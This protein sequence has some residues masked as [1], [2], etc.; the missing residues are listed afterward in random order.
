LPHDGVKI[1]VHVNKHT[2]HT[3]HPAELLFTEGCPQMD[4]KSPHE[5]GGISR[6]P[7]RRGKVA[8]KAENN[9]EMEHGE[10]RVAERVVR[11]EAEK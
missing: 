3:K 9:N 8:R 2:K 10:R 7:H 1:I 11:L 4:S 6:P 5:F